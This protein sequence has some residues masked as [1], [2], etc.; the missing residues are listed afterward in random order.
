M[1]LPHFQGQLLRVL[2]PEDVSE[3]VSCST[4][5]AEVSMECIHDLTQQ[6]YEKL[7]AAIAT[8]EH[9]MQGQAAADPHTAVVEREQQKL[10]KFIRGLPED[11]Q[12]GL[13]T[14]LQS[15]TVKAA[16]VVSRHAYQK[17][18]QPD[19]GAKQLVR[20]DTDRNHKN[21]LSRPRKAPSARTERIGDALELVG[22]EDCA[23]CIRI[24]C[25]GSNHC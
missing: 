1:Q 5:H 12:S 3:E 18:S 8:L 23:P 4:L 7:V 9:N 13:I 2:E 10:R 6:Q 17:P 20:R 14:E 24:T 22:S 25:C 15:L 19:T 16:D 21:L 11:A